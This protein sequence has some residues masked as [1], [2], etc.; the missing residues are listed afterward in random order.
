MIGDKQRGHTW[1]VEQKLP[2]L[3]GQG[4]PLGPGLGLKLESCLEG[5][6]ASAA[7]PTPPWQLPAK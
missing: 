2:L 7:L 3:T 4:L 1:R 6:A 5:L